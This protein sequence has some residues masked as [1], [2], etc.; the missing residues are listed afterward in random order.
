M[1]IF[2]L[3]RLIEVHG[4]LRIF[5]SHLCKIL[6]IPLGMVEIEMCEKHVELSSSFPAN[7]KHATSVIQRSSCTPELL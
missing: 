1:L 4:E 2:F 6:W 3:F 7:V 5:W